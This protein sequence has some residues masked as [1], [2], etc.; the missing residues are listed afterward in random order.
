MSE[1]RYLT[2]PEVARRL[3]VKPETVYA[4]VSRG[5]LRSIRQQGHRGSLFAL[6][7]VE[8]A[9]QRG[10]DEPSGVAER[11]QTSLTLLDPDELYY[12]G[13][14]VADLAVSASVESVA[15]LLW[16]GELRERPAF[17]AP[18]K[19]IALARKA[20]RVVP[21]GARLTD[22]VRVAVAVLGAADPLRFDLSP[23]AIVRA[24]E[25]LIGTLVDALPGEQP[26]K[27]L[28]ERLW[29]K[30]SLRQPR[31]EVLDAALVL[32][33]DH[34][35]AAST[36]AAR[37][38]ASVRADLYAVVSA[39]LGAVDG[40]YHGTASTLAY[41][42]LGE[43]MFDPV[44]AISERLRAGAKI[45]GFGHPLYQQRDPRA[46]ALFALLRDEPVMAVVEALSAELASRTFPNVE[47]ALA[48]MAHAYE[49]RPDAGEAV[50][51]L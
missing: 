39:G 48:A 34:G 2:T 46:E 23:E 43:A 5:L 45:P 12:R 44:G 15:H 7:D 11:I 4:Y 19:Q 8:R 32:L 36:M 41:R 47:L 49:M 25:T 1:E 3:G 29:P 35:L 38:A 17:P 16:T 37:V 18:R 21:G 24:A 14:R 40:Q 30:L 31:P 33:A 20:M 9:A 22:Q 27:S 6:S 13:H 42:F 51:A 50:F 26:G 28:G 10:G